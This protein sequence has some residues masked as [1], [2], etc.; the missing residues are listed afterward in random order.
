MYYFT[1]HI[2]IF[3]HVWLQNMCKQYHYAQEEMGCNTNCLLLIYILNLTLAYTCNINVVIIL[4][5]NVLHTDNYDMF[6]HQ[7][8]NSLVLITSL[9]MANVSRNM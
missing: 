5:Y 7:Y 1:L 9:Q 4:Y 8:E 2:M 3:T 6:L